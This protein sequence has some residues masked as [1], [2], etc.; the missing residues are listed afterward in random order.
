M[1]EKAILLYITI[2]KVKILTSSFLW[3]LSALLIFRLLRDVILA[4]QE[5][6]QGLQEVL[7]KSGKRIFAVIIAITVSSLVTFFKGFY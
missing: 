6:E 2:D 5:A 1:M 3:L 7:K 4:Y